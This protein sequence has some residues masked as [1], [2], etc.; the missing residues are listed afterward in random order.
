MIKEYPRNKNYLVSENGDIYSKRYNRRLTPKKNYDGYYRIQIW[1][2]GHCVFRSWHRIIA[3]TFIDNPNNL[4]FVNHKD[5]NKRNNQ[6]SNLEWCTQ[7]ENINHAWKTGLST[8]ENH[9]KYGKIAQYDLNGT[10]IKIYPCPSIAAESTGISYFTIL[11]S[12]KRKTKGKKY[13]WRFV[14]NCNDYPGREYGSY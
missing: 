11:N 1:K 13:S 10:F 3:E 9:S 2:K 6:V 7:K 14:E 5:G 12:A 8:K 4:P